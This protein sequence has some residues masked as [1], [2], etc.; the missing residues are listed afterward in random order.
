[1]LACVGFV[2]IF[3]SI[4]FGLLCSLVILL[5]CA[6]VD[7]KIINLTLNFSFRENNLLLCR[8]SI[9]IA[10]KLLSVPWTVAE[11]FNIFILAKY[12][13]ILISNPA[14]KAS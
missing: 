9:K 14:A 8:L 1:M 7:G 12:C 2:F 4:K 11:L 3:F 10:E 13:Y 5:C 6:T